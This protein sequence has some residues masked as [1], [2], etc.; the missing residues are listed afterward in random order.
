MSRTERASRAAGTDWWSKRPFSGI[1]VSHRGMKWWKRKSHKI[2]RRGGPNAG[3][4]G[5]LNGFMEWNDI[6]FVIESPFPEREDC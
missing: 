4:L 1:S 5:G 6:S 2:E 3:A